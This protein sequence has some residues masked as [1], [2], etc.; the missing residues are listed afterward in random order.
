[1]PDGFCSIVDAE[2]CSNPLKLPAAIAV[3][4]AMKSLCSIS[5]SEHSQSTRSI[6]WL[7]LSKLLSRISPF[8]AAKTRRPSKLLWFRTQFCETSDSKAPLL[9]T[10]SRPPPGHV[11]CSY[12]RYL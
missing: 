4:M 2:T 10:W 5:R 3:E 1:V 11:D 12:V 8:V 6:A 7:L 9:L